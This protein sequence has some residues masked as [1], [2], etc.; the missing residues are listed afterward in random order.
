MLPL[1]NRKELFNHRERKE[2]RKKL[3]LKPVFVLYVFFV[4]DCS[5]KS[6]TCYRFPRED[7]ILC[8]FVF[9]RGNDLP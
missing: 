2:H 4:V 7:F 3:L 1:F 8:P 9:F 5:G 6:A